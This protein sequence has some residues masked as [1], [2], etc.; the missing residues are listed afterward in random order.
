MRT[1]S[2]SLAFTAGLACF[3]VQLP[4]AEPSYFREIRPILQRQCQ[5]CH[6][7]AKPLGGF[8]MTD[9]ADLLKT[10][11]HLR[12]GLTPGRPD[13]S[14][15]VEQVTAKDGRPLAAAMPRLIS[16]SSAGESRNRMSAPSSTYISMRATASSMPWVGRQSVRA[17]IRMPESLA[18]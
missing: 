1:V 12:P 17:M 14:F 15:I 4:A 6:Q 11:D 10:G 3:A 7:P 5:G 9:Y 18:A 8:V 13:K 16:A 2:L